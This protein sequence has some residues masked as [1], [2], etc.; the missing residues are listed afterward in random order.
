MLP[1]AGEGCEEPGA[2][3]QA[4]SQ[5]PQPHKVLRVLAGLSLPWGAGSRGAG[6]CWC[7]P[8]VACALFELW[9][10]PDLL[11]LACPFGHTFD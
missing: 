4:L 7:W 5:R 6:D 11:R 3:S 2:G 1:G 9:G 8:G 10:D